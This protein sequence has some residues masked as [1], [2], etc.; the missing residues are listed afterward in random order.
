MARLFN[1]ASPLGK[2]LDSLADVVTF[3]VAPAMIIYQL[4][5]ISYSRE[6]DAVDISIIY[7][8]PA[9]IIAAAAAYRL[10]KFN[11]DERAIKIMVGIISF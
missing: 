8:L 5:R 2:Q 6:E 11:I 1:A 9:L 10:A 4:L 3:G 7:L